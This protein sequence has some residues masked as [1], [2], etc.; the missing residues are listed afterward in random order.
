MLLTCKFGL[1]QVKLFRGYLCLGEDCV[2]LNCDTDSIRGM[3]TYL[4]RRHN[5]SVR[6]D[7]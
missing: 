6:R 2:K 4:V 5:G 1:L 7:P 3:I